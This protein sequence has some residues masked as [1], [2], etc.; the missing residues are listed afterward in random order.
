MKRLMAVRIEINVM[1]AHSSEVGEPRIIACRLPQ[2]KN[3]RTKQIS[4]SD[5][6][7]PNVA[8]AR[9]SVDLFVRALFFSK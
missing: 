8:L 4:S 2:G 3:G 9:V 6:H 1:L 5:L 7:Q